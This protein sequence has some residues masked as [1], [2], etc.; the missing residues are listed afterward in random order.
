[1]EN[2]VLKY[3]LIVAREENI[4]KAAEILHISQPA[5]SR[6]LMQ[7]EEELGAKLF[8]RGKRNITLTDEGLYL[9]QKAQEIVDLTEKTEQEFAN[10]LTSLSGVISIGMGETAASSYLADLINEFLEEYPDVRF[11]IISGNADGTKEQLDKGLLD[12]GILLEPTDFSKYEFLRLPV[13]DTW[14]VLVPSKCPMCQKEYVTAEDLKDRKIFMSNRAINHS[15]FS[16]W[17]GKYYD[18]K[19]IY[20]SVNLLYNAAMLVSKGMGCAVTIDGAVQLYNHPELNFRPLYPK[21]KQTSVLV[22]KK[23]QMLSSCVLKFIEF[24]QCKLVMI[25]DKK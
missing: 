13:E 6:Q 23:N 20:V 11:E 22:W 21:I 16:S 19:N 24:V 1:M 25:N 15:L 17:F 12:I 7:L 8:I 14:G 2:R 18:E 10:G 3:F 4:T 5:L 9:R